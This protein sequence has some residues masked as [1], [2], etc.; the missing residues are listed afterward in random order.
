MEK[1]WSIYNGSYFKK[2][3]LESEPGNIQVPGYFDIQCFLVF[4][5]PSYSLFIYRMDKVFDLLYSFP[6]EVHLLSSDLSASNEH[7][8]KAW[9]HLWEYFG[10]K[11]AGL[12]AEAVLMKSK[13]LF[14][15]K[16][17]LRDKTC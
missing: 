15:A 10:F 8:V 5:P 6:L 1:S 16:G 9:A 2:H 4:F 12:K 17:L 7:C 11:S 13:Y 3:I 14:Q